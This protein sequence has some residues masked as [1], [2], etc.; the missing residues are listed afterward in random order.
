MVKDIVDYSEQCDINIG[1]GEVMTE[2]EG[3]VRVSIT[4]SIADEVRGSGD[5][6]Y[7]S[8]DHSGG[9]HIDVD[10]VTDLTKFTVAKTSYVAYGNEARMDFVSLL[11]NITCGQCSDLDDLQMYG[12]VCLLVD[13]GPPRDRAGQV[14][15]PVKKKPRF[16]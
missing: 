1:I 15:E 5:E 8:N 3:G 7:D 16:Y 14:K 10:W 13:V 4:G 11:R 12:N 2:Y 6:V 9:E